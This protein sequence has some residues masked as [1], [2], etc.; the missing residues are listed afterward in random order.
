MTEP[1]TMSGR[2]IHQAAHA[3]VT[4]RNAA[5][6]RT[7]VTFTQWKVL[8][9]ASGINRDDVIH[10][11]A[12]L[13]MN[14]RADI[15]AAIDELQQRDLL[16]A[17]GGTLGLTARGRAMREQISAVRTGLHRQLYDG[18]TADDL[19]ITQRVLDQITQRAKAIHA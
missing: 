17:D 3:L 6:D 1:V 13:T 5:L 9:K 10:Q 7:G 12:D 18:I 8:D 15:A 11:L 16:S 2:H 4:L 14:D 19:K